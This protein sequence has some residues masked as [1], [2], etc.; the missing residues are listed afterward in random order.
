MDIYGE[1]KQEYYDSMIAVAAGKPIALAE[2]GGL[3]SPEIL[4]KQPRWTYFMAWS[5]LVAKS[6]S[7]D[8]IKSVYNAPQ[9]LGRDDPRLSAPM[10]AIR[11]A[12]ADRT[13]GTPGSDAV[14]KLY[15]D[16][17]VVSLPPAH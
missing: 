2:V 9:V 10:E 7:V 12:T 3:P 1:F 13:A 17:H 15:A 14:Q 4:A 16:P 6:N 8:L 11:K 5:E